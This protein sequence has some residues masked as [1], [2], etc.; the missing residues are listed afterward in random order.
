MQQQRTEAEFGEKVVGQFI[1]SDIEYVEVIKSYQRDRVFHKR[2]FECIKIQ[3]EA[4][5]V[6][7]E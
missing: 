1:V 6:M 7:L 5:K 3:F 2:S 4:F